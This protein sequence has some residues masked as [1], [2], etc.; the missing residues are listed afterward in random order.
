M[1]FRSGGAEE[2]FCFEEERVGARIDG[3]VAASAV[4]GPYFASRSSRAGGTRSAFR[5]R[6]LVASWRSTAVPGKGPSLPAWLTLAF[7]QALVER[8][9]CTR[10]ALEPSLRQVS[11]DLSSERSVIALAARS[12]C[13][14][15]RGGGKRPEG[16]PDARIVLLTLARR[17]QFLPQ[18]TPRI[19]MPRN[20]LGGPGC[21]SKHACVSQESSIEFNF[22][23]VGGAHPK[24]HT[25][26]GNNELIRRS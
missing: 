25:R 9:G 8:R 23:S 15:F 13:L 3:A 10:E 1:H 14:P 2:Q 20:C 12:A 16:E 21:S 17:G 6:R 7:L 4:Q 18:L 11:G 19:R 26:P 24:R 22:K 5:M